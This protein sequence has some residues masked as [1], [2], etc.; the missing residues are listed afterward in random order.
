[1][2]IPF[3]EK[4]YNPAI[5]YNGGLLPNI[6]APNTPIASAQI[7][8]QFNALALATNQLNHRTLA[9]YAVG[10]QRTLQSNR[11]TLDGN[12][13]TISEHTAGQLF[14]YS[15]NRVGLDVWIEPSRANNDIIIDV[16]V[17]GVAYPHTAF[18]VTRSLIDGRTAYL[19]GDTTAYIN[20][21]T[22]A[23]YGALTANDLVNNWAAYQVAHSAPHSQSSMVDNEFFLRPH[24]F[25]F[26]VLDNAGSAQGG[27]GL[28]Y[29]LWIITTQPP[30]AAIAPPWASLEYQRYINDLNAGQA[31]FYLNSSAAKDQLYGS[32]TISVTEV[33][34]SAA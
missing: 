7:V 17:F 25:N 5:D 31:R 19:A 13:L 2:P 27:V 23:G 18:I 22:I 8:S 15:K 20:G 21:L 29:S 6:P 3:N 33:F 10:T 28:C 32:S 30:I 11:F 26:R 9:N 4:P 24:N 12:G 14:S 1:M 16:D 34:S